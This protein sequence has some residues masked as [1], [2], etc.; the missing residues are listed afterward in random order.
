M[1]IAGAILQILSELEHPSFFQFHKRD[2]HN[3]IY[4]QAPSDWKAECL[5]C[6]KLVETDNRHPARISVHEVT[7]LQLHEDI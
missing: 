5:I 7:I 2:F 1:K 4:N 3:K 6:T